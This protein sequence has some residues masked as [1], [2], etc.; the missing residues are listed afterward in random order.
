MAN[1][2]RLLRP[3]GRLVAVD[4]FWFTEW[5][6]EDVPAV[7]AEHYA[8]DTR[9]ELP[10]MH[11]D[12]PEPIL[13]LLTA[14]GFIAVRGG[15]P[16]RPRPRRWRAVPHHRQHT[17]RDRGPR[18]DRRSGP[19]DRPARNRAMWRVP[20]RVHGDLVASKRADRMV[21]RCPRRP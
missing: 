19:L 12:G 13:E 10:L 9:S 16:A 17:L 11:L 4:G 2:R 3:G 15:T 1:W 5:D 20:H 21:N 14:A 8:A 6:D 7:F 18:R